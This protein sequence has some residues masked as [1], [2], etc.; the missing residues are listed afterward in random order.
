MCSVLEFR[1]FSEKNS[2]LSAD[3]FFLSMEFFMHVLK[4]ENDSGEKR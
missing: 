3:V 1:M 4:T 2:T